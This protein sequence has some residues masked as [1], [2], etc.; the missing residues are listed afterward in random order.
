M[1]G[2][3]RKLPLFVCVIFIFIIIASGSAGCVT[4]TVTVSPSAGTASLTVVNGTQTKTF[5]M[6]DIKQLPVISGST[7]D[8]TS[9]GT[10]E[11]PYSYKGVDVMEVLKL[12]GGITANDAIRISAKDGYSMTFSYKQVAEGGEFPTYDST[13]GKEVIPSSKISILLAY[14]KDGKTIDDTVGPLRT[15][16]MA[17]GQLTDGHWNVKWTTKIEIVTLQQDWTLSLQGAINQD[18]D[19]ATF[20][21]GAAPGCH[22][23]SWTDAQ[24]HVWTGIPLWYLVCYVDDADTMGPLNSAVWDKGFEVHLANSNGDIVMYSSQ[25]VRKNENLIVTYEMDGQ[26]LPTTTW[27]LVLV[28]SDVDSQHQIGMITKIKLVFP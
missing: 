14:E 16:I 27:P 23:T 28:G 20:E 22:G 18:I 8:I 10:I 2:L 21:S 13:T 9:S 5:S 26:P 1:N 15:I 12:V 25:D 19:K 17:P 7:G 3:L 4:K 6:A 11:G 24:G